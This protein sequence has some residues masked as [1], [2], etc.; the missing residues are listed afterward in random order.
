MAAMGKGRVPSRLGVPIGKNRGGWFE[1]SFDIGH[2][3]W[4]GTLGG[5]PT[6]T[7]RCLIYRFWLQ[8]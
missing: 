8:D 1:G 7:H 5:E 6:A 3:I 4:A 2:S